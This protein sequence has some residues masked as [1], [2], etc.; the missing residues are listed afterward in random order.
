MWDCGSR[1]TWPAFRA[2]A[3]LAYSDRIPESRRRS[4]SARASL[5]RESLRGR[6]VAGAALWLLACGD[7]DPGLLSRLSPPGASDDAAVMDAAP[8]GRAPVDEAGAPAADAAPRDGAAPPRDGEAPDAND[9]SDAAADAGCSPDEDADVDCCPDDSAK[10][11]PGACGCGVADTNSDGDGAPDC[12]DACPNDATKTSTG[13]C[14]C[15]VPESCAA[16]RDALVHRYRFEGTGTTV[17]DTAGSAHGT[18]IGTVLPGNGTLPLAG[19]TSDQYVDLPNG[20]IS[21]RQDVTIEAWV[22]WAGGDPWQRIFDFGDSTAGT[23]GT[24]DEGRTHLFITP[25]GS[26]SSGTNLLALFRTTAG[27][28][29]A[30]AAAPLAMNV[31]KH[32][33]VVVDG[34]GDLMTLYLDGQPAA[35]APLTTPLS[36]I[37]DVNNWIGRSQWLVDAEFGGVVHEFRIYAAALGAPE[38]AFSFSAGTDPAFLDP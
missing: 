8:P 24:Q 36:D 21:G 5:H 14:G 15:G 4:R 10:T 31:M 27:E 1:R 37:N 20:L 35:S 30:Q 6:L 13:A 11:A 28:V 32:V 29:V 33:A 18:L 17:G 3:D 22:T 38:L 7:Y 25:Q 26:G 12:L 34:A 23:E 16:L 9:S 19:T 2:P